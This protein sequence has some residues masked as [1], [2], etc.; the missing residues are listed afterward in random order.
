VMADQPNIDYVLNLSVNDREQPE[1]PN[2]GLV[3]DFVSHEDGSPAE[4][5]IR[6]NMPVA[7]IERGLAAGLEALDVWWR[8]E[9]PNFDDASL[10]E[11]DPAFLDQIWT[12][13][14]DDGDDGE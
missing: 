2:F 7:D 4:L 6:G 8:T 3:L 13:F 5:I 9:S 10:G 11:R 1:P 12:P 14:S